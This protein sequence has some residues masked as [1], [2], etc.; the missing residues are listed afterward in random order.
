MVS[1]SGSYW[2]WRNTRCGSRCATGSYGISRRRRA[3][4]GRVIGQSCDLDRRGTAGARDVGN[5][6]G[7]AGCVGRN[8]STA[9]V[10]NSDRELYRAII[11]VYGGDSRR[12]FQ[13]SDTFLS[14]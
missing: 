12:W 14:G 9:V 3:G 7:A 4:I 10:S 11:V 2:Y 6:I 5:A 1:L 8:V 13:P